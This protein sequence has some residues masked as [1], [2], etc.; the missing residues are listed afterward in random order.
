MIAR[1][2][3]SNILEMNYDLL[4]LLVLLIASDSIR[5]LLR[6][7]IISSLKTKGLTQ[8]T[9]ISTA[10]RFSIA[11]CLAS[12]GAVSLGIAL[13]IAIFSISM[14][15]LLAYKVVELFRGTKDKEIAN[16]Q[17]ATGFRE[18]IKSIVVAGMAAW[19]PNFI[20]IAGSQLGII[21]VNSSQGANEAGLYF[22]SYSIV[23]AMLTVTSVLQ[24]IAYPALSGMYDGRKRFAWRML[25][26]TLIII[27]PLSSSII[28][29]SRDIVQIFGQQYVQSSSMLEIMA[30][31]VL[32]TSVAGFISILVYSYGNYRMVL[33]LGLS[34]TIPRVALYL[35]LVPFYGG[36]GAGIS[37]VLGSLG[38]LLAA[39]IISRKIKMRLQ[40]RVLTLLFIT[41]C[42]LSFI[43]NYIG[44]NYIFGTT[45]TIIVSYVLFLRFRVLDREDL[46]D[47]MAILPEKIRNP[48]LVNLLVLLAKRID[49]SF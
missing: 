23:M 38:G 17:P 33:A 48:R 42:V 2:W 13:S 14:A 45:V 18:T 20:Y 31:S 39:A 10:A 6:A 28:F 44:I 24:T 46:R 11:A 25:K 21:V 47:A 27:L 16:A 12:F 1:D 37:F 36:E 32:P 35:L 5:T 34:I 49:S 22:I 3:V 29:Y 4:F 9:V 30:L 26:L 8:V 15:I 41:P 7:I 43:L 19:I 40:W